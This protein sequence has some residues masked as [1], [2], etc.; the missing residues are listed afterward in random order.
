[1]QFPRLPP[2]FLSCNTLVYQTATSV[3]VSGA[4]RFPRAPGGC[5]RPRDTQR[6]RDGTTLVLGVIQAWT[7][8]LGTR[9][10]QHL[11]FNGLDAAFA[12]SQP[13]KLWPS[14]SSQER[15]A[16]SRCPRQYTGV[17]GG[18]DIGQSHFNFLCAICH[19]SYM[20]LFGYGNGRL[21]LLKKVLLIF[22]SRRVTGQLDESSEFH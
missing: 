15:R 10:K 12:K 18:E 17:V 14:V 22:I 5:T 21:T 4:A 13:R 7:G 8:T 9:L 11:G 19:T 16:A 3:P 2:C 6:H 1:M 20:S